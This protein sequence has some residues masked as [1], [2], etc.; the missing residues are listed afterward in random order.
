MVNTTARRK[1]ARKSTA[2]KQ[3]PA[4]T[5]TATQKNRQTE[6]T[7]PLL[8][9]YFIDELKDIYWAEKKLVTSLPRLQKAA[10]S[11]ELKDAL[12]EHLDVTREHVAR[13]ED[14]FGQLGEK[15]QAKKCEAMEGIIAETESVI[16]DTEQGT[17]TRD[18]AVIMAAQK[19]EHYEIATYGGL[20]QLAAT[21]G[22]QTIADLL[23]TTLEEEKEADETLTGIAEN[24]INYQAAEEN[25]EDGEEDTDE[26]EQEEEPEEDTDEDEEEEDAKK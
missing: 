2:K 24:D 9:E 19:A 1:T 10:G 17:A 26:E 5:R 11:E 16:E 20:R 12:G 18:V 14:I 7:E 15:A 22:L 25:K 23:N 21:M 4:R 3:T 8:R 6:N 13:L